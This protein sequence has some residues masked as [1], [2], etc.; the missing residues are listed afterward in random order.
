MNVYNHNHIEKILDDDYQKAAHWLDVLA[1][2]PLDEVSARRFALWLQASQQ[3]RHIFERMLNT[4]S[5]PGLAQALQPYLQAAHDFPHKSRRLR[6]YSITGF[7]H[8][9]FFSVAA[10]CVMVF[11]AIYFSSS[12]ITSNFFTPATL[13][14][15]NFST[16][17]AE[18]QDYTLADGSHLNLG[19]AAQLGVQ[20]LGDQR[21]IQ[22]HKGEAYFRVAP[23]KQRPFAVHINQASVVAVGTE[24]NVHKFSQGVDI[25]VYEGAVEVRTSADAKPELVRAGER[26]RITQGALAAIETIDLTQLVDWRSGWIEIRD[27]PLAY[28]VDYLNRYSE[29]PIRI[30][31]SLKEIRVAGRFRLRD[32]QMTLAMLE[33]Y[34]QLEMMSD[35][36]GILLR[37]RPDAW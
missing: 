13:A 14:A 12:W 25:T 30:H 24:F 2:A 10:C 8:P 33:Q 36:G 29:L 9:R 34:Y 21:L 3:R 7:L 26:V 16:D 35:A 1:D 6:N 11:I 32:T 27:E 22:L 5:D 23:D 17:Q 37:P 20:L 4:W 19:G 15:V 18:Q 28:L 31:S